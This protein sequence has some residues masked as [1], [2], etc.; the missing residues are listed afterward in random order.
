MMKVHG[1][2]SSNRIQYKARSS[3]ENSENVHFNSR[4]PNNGNFPWLI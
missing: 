1:G 4:F 2:T 3:L